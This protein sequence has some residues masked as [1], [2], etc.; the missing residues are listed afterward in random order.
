MYCNWI[1][2]FQFLNLNRCGNRYTHANRTCPAHPYHKPQR[3]SDLIL[4]PNS[5]GC[6]ENITTGNDEVSKWLENY[7]RERQDKTPTPGKNPPTESSNENYNYSFENMHTPP[8]SIKRSKTKR[9][10]ASDFIEQENSPLKKEFIDTHQPKILSTIQPST[11]NSSSYFVQSHPISFALSS[12]PKSPLRLSSAPKSPMRVP[13]SPLALISNNNSRSL[14]EE[15]LNLR[16]TLGDITSANNGQTVL[17]SSSTN[18]GSIGALLA[19]AAKDSTSPSNNV[20]NL[21][22]AENEEEQLNEN[23]SDS[24]GSTGRPGII[25]CL[26]R[27]APRSPL[28]TLKPKKRWLKTVYQENRV[29]NQTND[30]NSDENI[31]AMPIKWNE[32]ESGSSASTSTIPQSPKRAYSLFRNPGS[33]VLRRSPLSMSIASTLVALHSSSPDKEEKEHVDEND[34]SSNNQPLN[35]SK[36]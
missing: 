31:L 5:T 14:L 20:G 26:T 6:T 18:K 24:N 11:S 36:R 1:E 7:R 10:L 12:A 33:N 8:S 30:E 28:K 3:T 34:G 2:L 15:R 32:A 4:Q 9:G 21:I 27:P 19:A 23:S 29:V 17:G 13:G 16:K 22:I 25:Q 35:L